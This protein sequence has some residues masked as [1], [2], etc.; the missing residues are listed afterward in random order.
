MLESLLCQE[1]Y[2]ICS[3]PPIL[4]FHFSSS[5][6]SSSF[7][8]YS[9]FISSFW[10]SKSSTH[11]KYLCHV[12]FLIFV[13]EAWVLATSHPT[14]RPFR[15]YRRQ[16]TIIIIPMILLLFWSPSS[17]LFC[18]RLHPCIIHIA[19][20]IIIT[21]IMWHLSV[22]LSVRDY[23]ITGLRL[24]TRLNLFFFLTIIM[25]HMSYHVVSLSHHFHVN[26]C[27]SYF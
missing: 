21:N 15:H 24:N 23:N 14:G 8:S 7:P 13:F 20:I 18:N 25:I 19:I 1:L 3:S 10:L 17:F 26:H 4:L 27:N 5:S 2:S 22:G 11:S 9:A 16:V 12:F 6:S